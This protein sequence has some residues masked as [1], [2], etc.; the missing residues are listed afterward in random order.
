MTVLKFESAPRSNLDFMPSQTHACL[1]FKRL[2][3]LVPELDALINTW[4]NSLEQQFNTHSL[5]ICQLQ[6]RLVLHG[7]LAQVNSWRRKR[8]KELITETSLFLLFT[9]LCS[10]L[11]LCATHLSS[12]HHP[13]YMDYN[14]SQAPCPPL[15]LWGSF[16]SP[17]TPKP[18]T[19]VVAVSERMKGRKW[20]SDWLIMSAVRLLN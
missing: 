3:F 13:F 5:I 9:H 20:N 12:P 6:P 10:S 19:P 17:W 1:T 8:E 11:T 2:Y 7:P 4:T 16:K 15:G 14:P 18:K